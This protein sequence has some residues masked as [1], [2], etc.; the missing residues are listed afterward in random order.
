[1]RELPATG[2]LP[3]PAVCLQETLP[4]IPGYEILE[5]VGRGGMGVVYKA[6]QVPFERLVALKLIRDGALAGP[7]ERPNPY[8]SVWHLR[9]TIRRLV[10]DVI[11]TH[12]ITSLSDVG[13]IAMLGSR[14][15]WIHT[16]HYGNYP[17]SNSRHMLAERWL[18]RLPEPRI[19][20]Q[21]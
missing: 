11:H 15:R 3:A 20:S 7:Q 2:D 16:F 9:K 1:M 4:A 12:G 5:E 21:T 17:Y 18:S 14:P 6:R 19:A 8:L 13:T 10:P